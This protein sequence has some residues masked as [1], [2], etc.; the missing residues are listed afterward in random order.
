MTD[1]DLGQ[2]PT[3]ELVAIFSRLAAESKG[4]VSAMYEK[5]NIPVDLQD[6]QLGQLKKRLGLVA[7]GN[8]PDIRK[9]VQE[10]ETAAQGVEEGLLQAAQKGGVTKFVVKWWGCRLYISHSILQDS[11]DIGSLVAA[12]SAVCGPTGAA[13]AAAMG[14]TIALL[15]V[16]DRG[17]GIVLTKYA[18]IGPIIP[19]RQ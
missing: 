12:V 16:I 18:W 15:K 14:I 9:F 19:T 6:G 7:S 1:V 10:L 3:E 5:L 17:N 11:S 13:I 8:K 4:D 2:F